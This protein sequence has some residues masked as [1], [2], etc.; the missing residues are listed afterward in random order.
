MSQYPEMVDEY[1]QCGKDTAYNDVVH[2]LAALD[3]ENTNQNM[4][5]SK[6]TIVIRYKTPYSIQWYGPFIL[7]F[8]LGHDVN[9]RCVLGLPTLLSIRTAITLLSSEI[10]CTKIN[11]KFHLL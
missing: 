5:H 6:M 1:L 3:R 8:T 11:R 9:L 10:S 2:L 7:S 4:D